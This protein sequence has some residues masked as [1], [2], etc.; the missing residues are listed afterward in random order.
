MRRGVPTITA[1][2]LAFLIGR[3]WSEIRRNGLLTLASVANITVSLCVLGALFLAAVNLEHMANREAEKALLTVE[4]SDD[5]DHTQVEVDIYHDLRVDDVALITKEESLRAIFER[6]VP[7]AKA[8]DLVED[9]PLPDTMRVRPVDPDDIPAL[10]ETLGPIEGIDRVRYGKEIITKLNV[11]SRSVKIAGV[12]LL[13]LMA[14]GMTLI[15]NATIRLTVYA[16]RHEIRIMQLVGATNRFIKI[17][18]VCE[19]IFHGLMGG[20]VAAGLVLG[21]YLQTVAYVDQHLAFIELL[22]GTKLI[23]LFGLG[24][25]VGGVVV[26]GT[27]SAMSLRK[28]LRLT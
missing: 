27:G 24:M 22:Y 15:V 19:G 1:N 25:V 26:G 13:T 14:F 11:V 8:M 4:L 3:A 6:Y 28:Y 23:V 12:V 16:R 5:A 20:I 2:T 21:G 9:N 17:P 10:A 18:F 7:N